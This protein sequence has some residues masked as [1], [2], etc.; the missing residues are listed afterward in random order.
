M[1][2]MKQNNVKLIKVHKDYL[3][4]A[5]MILLA[6]CTIAGILSLNFEHFYDVVNQYG[7]TVEM[8]SYGSYAHDT[9]FH[10]II[11]YGKTIFFLSSFPSL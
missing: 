9:Y 6:V 3:A 1:N 5:T 7:Q 4:V 10:R 8:Y 2:T 11:S